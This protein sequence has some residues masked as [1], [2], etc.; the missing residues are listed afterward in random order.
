M[1]GNVGLLG[2]YVFVNRMNFD[3]Q[4]VD[5]AAD[6][7]AQNWT[8]H[9]ADQPKQVVQRCPAFLAQSNDGCSALKEKIKKTVFVLVNVFNLKL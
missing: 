7:T 4:I 1:R 5:P 9:A 2:L 6:Y 8:Q 3:Q